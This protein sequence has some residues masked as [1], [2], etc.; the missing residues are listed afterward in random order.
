MSRNELSQAGRSN[1]DRVAAMLGTCARC[2]LAVA[3]PVLLASCVSIGPTWSELSGARY[4]VALMD[5]R[6]VIVSRVDGESTPLRV[7]I[8]ITPGR[9]EVTVE[10]LP[11]GIFPGGY[12]STIVI[13]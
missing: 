5:R 7:P 4:H 8:K 6:P 1:T 9:R 11:H 12:Y 13:D 10:S 2:G 3:L